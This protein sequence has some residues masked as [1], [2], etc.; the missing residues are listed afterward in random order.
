MMVKS[1]QIKAYI[2]VQ[3]QNDET[4]FLSFFM[5]VQ[6][7]VHLDKPVRNYSKFFFYGSICNKLH[8]TKKLQS[9]TFL[10]LIYLH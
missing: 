2:K 4:T 5:P 6:K 7:E 10:Y 9:F 1:I 3:F 8:V